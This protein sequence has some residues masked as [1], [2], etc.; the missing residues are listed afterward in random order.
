MV[1]YI[2]NGSFICDRCR[3]ICKGGCHEKLTR[4]L[5]GEVAEGSQEYEDNMDLLGRKQIIHCLGKYCDKPCEFQRDDFTP[6]NEED[7]LSALFGLIG[8]MGQKLNDLV[9]NDEK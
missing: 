2:N 6:F 7:G 9:V 1:K 4:M 3:N 5:S 8:W